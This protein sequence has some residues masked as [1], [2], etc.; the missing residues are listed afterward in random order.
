[1]SKVIKFERFLAVMGG[2]LAAI[3]FIGAFVVSDDDPN[4]FKIMAICIVAVIVG[5]LILFAFCDIL[6]VKARFAAIYTLMLARWYRRHA[7]RI[8]VAS[9]CNS[10]VNHSEDPYGQM[11]EI[12]YKN[13]AEE[14][15]D[16]LR[17]E[18]EEIY[19]EFE[20]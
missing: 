3:G 7:N 15:E 13:Y 17:E 4:F 11:F 19:Y 16:E 1:M 20:D 2:I 18:Y 6:A 5:G 14:R 10:F 8:K 12:A 9:K